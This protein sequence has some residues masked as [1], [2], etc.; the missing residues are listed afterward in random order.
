MNITVIFLL[1]AGTLLALAMLL[2]ATSPLLP[3]AQPLSGFA[4]AAYAPCCNPAPSW[5][6]RQPWRPSVAEI[7]GR[8]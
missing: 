2:L 3:I 8:L 6:V 4:T 1:Y 5:M 7:A